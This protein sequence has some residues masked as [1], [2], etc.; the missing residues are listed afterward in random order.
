MPCVKK[1][2]AMKD[3][4]KC[5]NLDLAVQSQNHQWANAWLLLAN[6]STVL[7][8]K[9][10]LRRV[11]MFLML[12]YRWRYFWAFREAHKHIRVFLIW[13]DLSCYWMAH[14]RPLFFTQGAFRAAGRWQA[15]QGSQVGCRRSWLNIICITDKAD[16]QLLLLRSK[17]CSDRRPQG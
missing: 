2:E 13:A 1:E 10:T 11:P 16:G 6:A 17:L 5:S 15:L 3:W 7:M 4:C 9:I 8:A 12:K 14:I